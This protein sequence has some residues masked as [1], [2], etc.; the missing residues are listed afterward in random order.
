M[1]N[2]SHKEVLVTD[3]IASDQQS[4]NNDELCEDDK[5]Y[6]SE[7]KLRKSC[8]ET[9]MRNKRK[10]AKNTGKS[11]ISSK[12]KFVDAKQMRKSCNSCR[13]NCS[14]K[15]CETDRIKNFESFYK[16][17]DIGKQRSFLYRHMRIFSPKRSPDRVQKIRKIQRHFYL[18]KFNAIDG[19]SELVKVCRFMFLNTFCISSQMLDTIYRKFTYNGVID[20]DQRGKYERH[21][22]R[23][24]ESKINCDED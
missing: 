13:L 24:K 11:Y 17:G 7:S 9:W 2:S 19:S 6:T 16:L 21:K 20:D 22:N 23:Q 4:D 18:E 15:V 1:V 12:G 3:Q 10:A 8:K 5:T 14:E